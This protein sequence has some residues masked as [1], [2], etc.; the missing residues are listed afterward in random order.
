MNSAKIQPNKAVGVLVA[1]TCINLTIGML[2]AWSVFKKAMVADWGWT[3]SQGN[4]AY[5]ISAVLLGVAILLG[6]MTRP[7]RTQP[8]TETELPALAFE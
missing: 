1:G 5:T 8:E 6:L 3:H 2:Y 7:V 4:A